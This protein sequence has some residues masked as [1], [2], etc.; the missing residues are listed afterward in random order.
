PGNKAILEHPAGMAFGPDR[1]GDSVRDLYVLGRVSNNIAVYDGNTGA[2]V[3]QYVPPGS[4]LNGSAWLTF[5]PNGDLFTSTVTATGKRDSILR[6]D[7]ATNLVST[8][9]SN[10]PAANGGLDEIGRAHV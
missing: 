4:G 2:Y 6:V 10:D 7:H 1:N 5:G 9:V 3:E 8:F